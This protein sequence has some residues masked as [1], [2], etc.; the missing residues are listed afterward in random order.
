MIMPDMRY[1]YTKPV[2]PRKTMEYY[3]EKQ[4][5]KRQ[6]ALRKYEKEKLKD[7]QYH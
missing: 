3:L 1:S 5:R 2:K 4:E 7:E 6:K